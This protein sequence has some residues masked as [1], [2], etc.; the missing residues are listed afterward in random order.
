MA[1]TPPANNAVD[2]ALV[3]Y[4]PPANSAVDFEFTVTGPATVSPDSATHGHTADAAALT[5]AHSLTPDSASHAHT[6][7]QAGLTQ[8]LWLHD[9]RVVQPISTDVICGSS[10][11]KPGFVWDQFLLPQ[12]QCVAL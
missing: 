3:A 4:T 2:F 8:G 5:Q 12:A 10:D 1:Y 7:D 11:Y 6:A 9:G